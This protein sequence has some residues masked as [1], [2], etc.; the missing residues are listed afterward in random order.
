MKGNE[1]AAERLNELKT[2]TRNIT[3]LLNKVRLIHPSKWMKRVR[4]NLLTLLNSPGTVSADVQ[5]ECLLA[6]LGE[7]LDAVDV[8]MKI[9]RSEE[10]AH[11]RECI[12]GILNKFS[13]KTINPNN[14]T[15]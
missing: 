11:S 7:A 6:K 13:G 4:L 2:E 9:S 14:N 1:K 8:A 12:V 3:R 10:L 5:R 15:L